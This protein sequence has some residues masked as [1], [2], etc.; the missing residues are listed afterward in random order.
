MYKARIC[1]ACNLS[2]TPTSPSQRFCTEDCSYQHRLIYN[3]QYKIDNL[4]K[5]RQWRQNRIDK[6]RRYNLLY[7]EKV[8]QETFEAYGNKCDCCGETEQIFLSIDHIEG[9][10]TK[11]L[12]ELGGGGY[13]FYLWLRRQGF[14]KDKFRLLCANCQVGY[15]RG[16]TCPHQK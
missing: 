11:H 8:R 6:D 1:E 10:G 4:D 14:P 3:R 15:A 12:K 16:G 9:G 7:R 2:Y 5:A 13:I